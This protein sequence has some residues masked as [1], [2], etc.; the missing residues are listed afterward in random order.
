MNNKM[1]TDRS[2]NPI[3][4]RST[5]AALMQQMGDPQRKCCITAAQVLHGSRGLK[6]LESG[7]LHQ[8]L[9][10]QQG[11][12]TQW[13]HTHERTGTSETLAASASNQSSFEGE[14]MKTA[15]IPTYLVQLDAPGSRRCRSLSCTCTRSTA[16]T[17]PGAASTW[18][19]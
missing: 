6:V 13:R 16:A 15:T 12:V 14:P 2:L 8:V 4:V 17:C 5:C 10:L 9:L 3:L 18:T 11:K 7:E 19:S 1:R